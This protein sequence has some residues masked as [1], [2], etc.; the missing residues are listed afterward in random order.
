MK[1]KH[2]VHSDL[3]CVVQ[4]VINPFGDAAQKDTQTFPVWYHGY[5]WIWQKHFDKLKP[6]VVVKDI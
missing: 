6:K 1:K 2:T 3:T 5:Y 4:Y